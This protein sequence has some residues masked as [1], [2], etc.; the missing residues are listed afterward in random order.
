[1]ATVI[2][3]PANTRTCLREKSANLYKQKINTPDNK[4]EIALIATAS[5]YK[6]WYRVKPSEIR[7]MHAK[8]HTTKNNLLK[9]NFLKNLTYILL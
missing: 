1:M 7:L 6:N 9:R 5:S 3:N 4:K 8:A 2:C